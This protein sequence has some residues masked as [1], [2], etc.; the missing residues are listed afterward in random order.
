MSI[1]YDT[2]AWLRRKAV[3]RGSLKADEESLEADPN[4]IRLDRR[5]SGVA[6][7]LHYRPYLKVQQGY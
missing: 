2:R 1:Y 5:G 7:P 3:V 4:P 6:N